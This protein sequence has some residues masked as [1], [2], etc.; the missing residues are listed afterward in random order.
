MYF[1][2]TSPAIMWQE[3][4]TLLC[5]CMATHPAVFDMHYAP[6]MISPL[7]VEA[8]PYL[9]LLKIEVHLHSCIWHMLLSNATQAIISM[10]L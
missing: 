8:L 10:K 4:N 2:S 7:T 9:S 3:K 1:S 5:M 6:A